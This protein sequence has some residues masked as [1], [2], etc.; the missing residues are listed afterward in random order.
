MVYTGPSVSD[1]IG[2]KTLAENII[3]YHD[4]PTSDS[5]LDDDNLNLLQRFVEDPRSAGQS[6]NVCSLGAW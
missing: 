6:G 2:N 1:M 4:H 3:K 5:I